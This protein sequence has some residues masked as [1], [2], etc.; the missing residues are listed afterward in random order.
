MENAIILLNGDYDGIIE[1]GYIIVADGG[2]RIAQRLNVTPN[3]ILGDMDSTDNTLFPSVKRVVFNP[4]KDY[5]DGELCVKYAKDNG[6]ENILIYGVEGGRLDHIICNVALLKYAQ[7]LG[8]DCTLM[9]NK[10]YVKLINNDF[11][12]KANIG[13]TVSLVPFCGD[14]H[15]K[16][17]DGLK[18]KITDCIIKHA[19]AFGISDIAVKENIE[20]AIQSGELLIFHFNK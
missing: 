9:L 19:T 4:E 11:K 20:I 5:T 14:V 3:V 2:S 8:L 10:G 18:Y 6:F 7:N 1:K 16:Y 15:I 13:E 17:T 12:F